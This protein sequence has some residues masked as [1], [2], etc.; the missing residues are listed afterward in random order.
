[1]SAS[2]E[3]GRWYVMSFRSGPELFYFYGL[4]TLKNGRMQGAQIE[5]ESQPSPPAAAPQDG[6]GRRPP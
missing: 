3:M 4:S 5:I 6:L 1:M 2:M